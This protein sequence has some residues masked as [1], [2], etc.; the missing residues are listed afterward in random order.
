LAPGLAT[1]IPGLRGP[2]R[3]ADAMAV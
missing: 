3:L 2:L 1:R